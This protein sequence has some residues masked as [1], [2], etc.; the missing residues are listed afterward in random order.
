MNHFQEAANI[1]QYPTS[2]S[3]AQERALS[4]VVDAVLAAESRV[5]A[6]LARPDCLRRWLLAA[7]DW[8]QARAV[9]RARR[10]GLE[11]ERAYFV[12][13]RMLWLDLEGGAD[14]SGDVDV[15]NRAVTLAEAGALL[16]SHQLSLRA[17]SGAHHDAHLLGASGDV[18]AVAR[19]SDCGTV[20]LEHPT[21]ERH[22][23]ALTLPVSGDFS[24]LQVCE[25]AVQAAL[26]GHFRP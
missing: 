9:R 10:L 5:N 13:D 15:L 14:V 25:G 19:L 12:E 21:A 23:R 2:P 11:C 24:P 6:Y 8:R 17:L 22:D 7:A 18:L 16:R 4:A 20:T 26:A 1:P 3:S